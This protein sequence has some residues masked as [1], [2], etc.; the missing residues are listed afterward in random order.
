[1]AYIKVPAGFIFPS[2]QLLHRDCLCP[3]GMLMLQFLYALTK[4]RPGN[5]KCNQQMYIKLKQG[6]EWFECLLAS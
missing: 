2:Q 6:K 5:A 1:M 4:V 3:S